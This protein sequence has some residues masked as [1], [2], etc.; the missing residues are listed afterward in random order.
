VNS[1]FNLQSGNDDR[2]ADNIEDL[3]LH[4]MDTLPASLQTLL[5]V[6]ALLGASFEF[7]HVVSIMEEY[8]KVKEKDKATHAESVRQNLDVAVGK[9]I[10]VVEE[11]AASPTDRPHARANVT[12]R[13]VHDL[14]RTI[15]LKLSLDVWKR[16]M[17][18]VILESQGKDID[19]LLRLLPIW[20]DN[21]SRNESMDILLKIC[22]KFALAGRDDLCIEFFTGELAKHEAIPS[23][24]PEDEAFNLVLLH[25]AM[26]RS[27]MALLDIDES[28]ESF[29][30][31]LKVNSFFSFSR[32]FDQ[33]EI[34]GISWTVHSTD[35]RAERATRRA[36]SYFEG[37]G[38][39]V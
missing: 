31:G 1:C 23:A 26:G 30:V 3:I 4:K 20:T 25:V 12:F 13:F 2:S 5:S 22:E 28:R 34:P 35:T 24:A 32:R 21:T 10:L 11:E 9:G 36:P 16:K 8:D 37:G 29:L 18:T 14:W 39:D 17:R 7:L 15:L 6:A 38:W 27:F 19:M 33:S